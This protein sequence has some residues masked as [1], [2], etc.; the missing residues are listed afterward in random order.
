MSITVISNPNDATL[1]Q[2]GVFDWPTWQ[3]NTSRFAWHY[4][5]QETCYL[6]EGE[7]IVTPQG[8]LP[9]TIQAGNLVTFEQGLDCEWHIIK[10]VNKHYQFK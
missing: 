1:K 4:E 6:I 3:K 8:G 9:V 10:P 7:V 2:L 5:V